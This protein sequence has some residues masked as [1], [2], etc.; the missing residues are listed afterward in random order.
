MYVVVCVDG[1]FSKPFRTY[2]AKDSVY[3]FSNDMI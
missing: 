1:K 3:N 2:L